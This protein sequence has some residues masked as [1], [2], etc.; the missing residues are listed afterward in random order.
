MCGCQ[1]RGNGSQL[2]AP[3]AKCSGFAALPQSWGACPVPGT[4]LRPPDWPVHS[5]GGLKF[6]GP[7]LAL[8]GDRERIG[9]LFWIENPAPFRQDTGNCWVGKREYERHISSLRYQ[10]SAAHHAQ[11]VRYAPCGWRAPRPPQ[12]SFRETVGHSLLKGAAGR[13]LLGGQNE[14]DGELRRSARSSRNI[15]VPVRN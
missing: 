2:C 15:P 3:P 4:R 14:F 8:S 7:S 10:S 12:R 6:P 1:V 5:T 13:Q 11:A 9:P